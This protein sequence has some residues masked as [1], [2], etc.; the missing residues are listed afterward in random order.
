MNLR[1]YYSRGRD[2]FAD[3]NKVFY[4]ALAIGT[5][6]TIIMTVFYDSILPDTANVYARSVR[7]IAHGNWHDGIVTR[8]PMFNI[9]L[10]GLLAKTGLEAVSA[11]TLVAGVFYCATCF[12]LR[13]FLERYVTQQ[14]A[15]WGCVLYVSASL[16]MQFACSPLLESTRIFFLIS[17]IYLFF[18][19]LE[20]PGWKKGVLFGLSC[21]FLMVSRGEGLPVALALLAGFLP[22]GVI[23]CR[24]CG[25]KKQAAVWFLGVVFALLAVSPFC[26][27]NY[28]KS[29]YFV[30]D[31]RVMELLTDIGF[32]ENNN[33]HKSVEVAAVEPQTV[34]NSTADTGKTTTV[35]PYTAPPAENNVNLDVQKLVNM[36][37]DI[38]YGAGYLYC[39]LAV[40]GLLLL[41]RKKA[42][43]W[44]Y[45]LFAG[46]TM[47]H[48]AVYWVIMVSSERY[49]LFMVPLFMMFTITG[50]DFIRQQAVK[51]LP[52]YALVICC[53]LCGAMLCWQVRIG[54]ASAFYKDGKRQKKIA[55]FI[56]EYSR[57][58]FPDRQLRVAS[59]V[60]EVPCIYWS[61]AYHVNG[62]D[63]ILARVKPENIYDCD[64][65][66]VGKN[67]H[68]PLDARSDLERIPDAPYPEYVRIYRKKQ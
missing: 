51:Y 28:N 46:I 39:A 26:L 22:W 35:Q 2:F 5:I 62:Y 52:G 37:K 20:R 32:C 66:V 16:M 49:Y 25:F 53:V 42:L 11:L 21:G 3:P 13:K 48:L 45:L 63:R 59:S 33:I 9:L 41:I 14:L 8:A 47:L 23:F 54:I 31:M 27:M 30:T 17:A 57:K 68:A 64:M 38:L 7:Y 67:D 19:T 1:Q 65:I 6:C 61:N 60:P 40:L 56:D 18:E 12:P 15:A 4:T 43:R 29:G 44:D 58:H 24:H 10:A 34:G 55:A 36:G 50:V